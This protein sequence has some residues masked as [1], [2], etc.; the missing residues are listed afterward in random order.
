MA[1]NDRKLKILQTIAAGHITGDDIAESLGSSLQLLNYYLNTL[2]EDGY[3]KVAKVYDNFTREFQVVRAYLT[4]Q[5][6]TALAEAGV[7][8]IDPPEPPSP[9]EPA[10]SPQKTPSAPTPDNLDFVLIARSIEGIAQALED[11]PPNRKELTA[12]YLE[13]LTGEINIAYKRRPDRLKAYFFA[14]LNTVL[15]IVQQLPQ[16][17]E[18]LQ[19]TKVLAQELGLPIKLPQE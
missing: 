12:V 15:P 16:S 10:P 11:L 14:I 17:A 18:F 8:P 4:P 13:D 5:G 9:P 7:A 3:L 19:H 6:Q 2:S 1:L